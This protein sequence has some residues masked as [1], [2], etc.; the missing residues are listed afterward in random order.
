MLRLSKAMAGIRKINKRIADSLSTGKTAEQV[1]EIRRGMRLGKVQKDRPKEACDER[2][3]IAMLSKPR[4][5][6]TSPNSLRGVLCERLERDDTKNGVQIGPDTLSLRGVE[7]DP[8]LL[9]TS[10]LE[11]QRLLGEGSGARNPTN[12]LRKNNTALPS[13]RKKIVEQTQYVKIQKMF[14]NNQARL[15]KY[16]LDGNES[17]AAVSPSLEV[18]LAFKSRW[19]VTEEYIGLGQF[20]SVG[21]AENG[22]F[23][24]LISAAEVWENLRSIKNG[25][26]AGPDGITKAALLKWDPSGAKLATTF[27]VWLT[28]ASALQEVQDNFDTQ[29]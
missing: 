20:K 27:S 11:L 9:N 28:T 4:T 7:Q 15:G 10:A 5:P 13:E 3:I 8:A 26:A 12:P 14:Q 22:E 16:I 1:F 17:G 29:D 25:T 21:E 19:E 6:L 18:A 2:S 24:S 23:R